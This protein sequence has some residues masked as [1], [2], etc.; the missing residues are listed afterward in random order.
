VAAGGSDWVVLTSDNPRS[1]DPLRIIAEAEK[2]VREVVQTRYDAEERFHPLPGPGY[3]VMPDRRK[4]IVLAI[5]LLRP[6]D[7][8]LIAGKGHEDYQ[9]LGEKRI[10]FDDREEALAALAARAEGREIESIGS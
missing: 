3:F 9:I 8:V 5:R 1:E 4:A 6:G 2:G 10:H 7:A